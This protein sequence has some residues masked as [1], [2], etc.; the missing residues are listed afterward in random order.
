MATQSGIQVVY[1][2]GSASAEMKSMNGESGSTSKADSDKSMGFAPLVALALLAVLGATVFS[3]IALFRGGETATKLSA[4]LPAV[5]LGFLLVQLMIG[6]PAKKGII[7]AMS[8]GSSQ[9]NAKHDDF[10]ELESSMAQAMMMQIRVKTTPVFYLE[11]LALG[12]PTLLLANGL[13]DKY[14]RGEQ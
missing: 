1:G 3:G 7:E 8:E 13:I 10:S 5:A 14:K 9:A 2:G 4:V 11:L 6:F 12:I